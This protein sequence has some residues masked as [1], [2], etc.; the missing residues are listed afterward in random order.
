MPTKKGEKLARYHEIKGRGDPPEPQLLEQPIPPLP[1][2]HGSE[3][4]PIM[5]GENGNTSELDTYDAG[6][7]LFCDKVVEA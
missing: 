5:S 6:E 3:L 4:D 1:P 7:T 2:L